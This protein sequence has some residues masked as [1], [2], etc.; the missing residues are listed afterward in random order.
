M[1][2]STQVHLERYLQEQSLES[3]LRLRDAVIAS[4]DYAPYTSNYRSTV[5]SLLEREKYQEAIDY[6]MSVMD[7]WFLN[8]GI[9]RLV[10]F[11]HYKLG[12]DEEAGFE[13]WM[14]KVMVEGI[15]STGDGSAESPYLVLHTTD[16]YDVLEH[17]GKETRKQALVKGSDKQYDRHDCTDGSQIWFDVTTPYGFL[18]RRSRERE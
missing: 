17:L 16:E 15:A 5:G 3:F 18:A 7:N 9:H 8:P 6:L 1:S 14:Y 10:S 2:E 4:P 13:Y 12:R 11:A